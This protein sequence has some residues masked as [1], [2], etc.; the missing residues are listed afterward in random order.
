MDIDINLDRVDKKSALFVHKIRKGYYMNFLEKGTIRSVNELRENAPY[1]R[2]KTGRVTS[3]G[4]NGTTV[5][6]DGTIYTD[7]L[8]ITGTTLD[9]DDMVESEADEVGRWVIISAQTPAKERLMS[10]F[11]YLSTCRPMLFR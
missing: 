2:F 4:V 11:E 7:L 3:I 9:V 8:R 1:T 6:I 10:R 5:M